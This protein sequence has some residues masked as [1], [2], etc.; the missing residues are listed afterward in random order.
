MSAVSRYGCGGDRTCLHVVRHWGKS[1]GAVAGEFTAAVTP[2]AASAPP[3]PP[4]VPVS[5][6]AELRRAWA[7]LWAVGDDVVVVV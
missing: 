3:M 7:L 5:S 6:E 4:A 1:G 2:H